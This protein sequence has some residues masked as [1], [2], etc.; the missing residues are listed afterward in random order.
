LIL[1]NSPNPNLVALLYADWKIRIYHLEIQNSTIR[2][3]ARITGKRSKCPNCLKSSRSVRSCYFRTLADLPMATNAVLISLWIR[4]FACTNPNCEKRIFSERCSELTS[5]YSRRTERASLYLKQ[6][7]IEISS[8]KGAYFSKLMNIPISNNTCLRLVKSMAMPVDDNLLCIGIDDWAKRKGMNY[9]SIIVNAETGRPI[10]LLN[11]RDSGDVVK[12]LSG[13]QEI[14]YV[15][16]DRATSYASAIT[17]ALPQ[18]KQIADRFHLVKNL[19]DAIQEEI[20]LEYSH[21][22]EV[23]KNIYEAIELKKSRKVILEARN[24][25]QDNVKMEMSSVMIQ[26]REKLFQITKMKKDG[27]NISDIARRTQTDRATIVKYLEHGIPSTR[28]R[29]TRVNYNRYIAEINHMVSLEINPTAM[30]KSLKNIGLKCCERS[31]TRW[32]NIKFHDYQ[33]KWNRAC[34]EPLKITKP[35]IWINYIPPLRKLSIF[36]TNPEYGVAKDTG[37]CSKEKEIVDVLVNEI[38]LLSSLRNLYINFRNILKGGCHEKLD[39]W[40]K[41]AQSIGLKKIDRFC[42]GLK[43]DI[44]AVKNAITYNWTNG[45]VEGNVNRLKNK[46]REMYGRCGFQL[47]RRKVC[48]SVTG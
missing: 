40:I 1:S 27:H 29:S 36:L 13:H 33:H 24:D 3:F 26:K 16:R 48:L 34:H 23:A 17:K 14:K 46:K 10:D 41:N 30:F 44:V 21:L 12:W 4:R 38:P 47:L 2:L 45:L 19:G 43:K 8:N 22:K 9:G 20:K 37:E 7:I 6:F 42:N 35:Q 32:F 5:P 18:A 11:I 15:T 28:T 39:I 25:V 31:F